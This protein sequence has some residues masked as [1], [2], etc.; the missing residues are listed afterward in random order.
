MKRFL[1][2]LLFACTP[3]AMQAQV[4]YSFADFAQSNSGIS[5]R[6][7]FR[8]SSSDADAIARGIQVV[9]FTL[10]Q[11]VLDFC[12]NSAV[13]QNCDLRGQRIG[14]VGPVQYS[15]FG[16]GGGQFVPQLGLYDVVGCSDQCQFRQFGDVLNG[17]SL[18]GCALPQ[19]PVSLF[20]GYA[21][22]TC[23]DE[24]FTGLFEIDVRIAFNYLG[25]GPA[26]VFDESDFGTKFNVRDF[27]PALTTVPE[28]STWAMTLIGL[29][30]VG[31]AI[32]RKRTRR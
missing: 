23:S 1:V 32:R 31:L 29:G 27:G 14:F 20:F 19:P 12:A 9:S 7:L 16:R 17:T 18:L 21:G 25:T 10:S 5:A 4:T 11:R 6:L 13:V 24:G 3:I 26:P 2:A 22:R 8:N 15:A 30:V 28:P